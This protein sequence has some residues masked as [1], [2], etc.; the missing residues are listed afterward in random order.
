MFGNQ[1]AHDFAKGRLIK[2]YG[3][4]RR[5]WKKE[6]AQSHLFLKNRLFV[7]LKDTNGLAGEIQTNGTRTTYYIREYVVEYHPE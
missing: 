4:E 1:C 3:S 6:G 2:Q 5:A 7:L